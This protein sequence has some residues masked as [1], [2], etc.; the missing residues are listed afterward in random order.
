MATLPKAGAAQARAGS[1]M[2]SGCSKTDFYVAPPVGNRAT[3]LM[4]EGVFRNFDLTFEWKIAPGGNSGLKYLVGSSQKLVFQ[5]GGPP[6]IE[7]A[8]TAGPSA[9]FREYTSG[10]EYQFVDEERHS[11]GKEDRTRSGSLYRI[12]GV[13]RNVANPAGQLNQSPVLLDGNH[14]EHWL[15]GVRVV[16]ANI[17]SAEFQQAAAQ[18]PARTRRALDYRNKEQP[19]ALQSHTGMV[20]VR[21][22][23]LRRLPRVP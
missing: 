9:I 16:A 5:E 19:L 8:V 13:H 1:R 6:G 18:A 12:L 11:D 2:D 15:N 21:N 22:I 10:F 20:W 7:G 17:A 14:L 4:T 23:K 3:D